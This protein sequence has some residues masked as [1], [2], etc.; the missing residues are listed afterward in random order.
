MAEA[1]IF[2]SCLRVV[3][4]LA[5]WLPVVAIP[6]ELHV[7]LVGDDVVG[8]FSHGQHVTPC[9]FRTQRIVTQ[10]LSRGAKPC[11]GVTTLCPRTTPLVGLIPLLRIVFAASAVISQDITAGMQAW[12][13]WLGWHKQQK[14]RG[15]WARG[16]GGRTFWLTGF[17]RILADF[18]FVN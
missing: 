18:V 9:A 15:F 1:T 16:L 14:T 6:E 12:G 3:A 7:P 13:W 2:A 17:G 11:V 10:E 5:Q 4:R 8:H